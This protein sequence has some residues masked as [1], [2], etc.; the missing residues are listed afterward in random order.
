MLLNPHRST[1]T[2]LQYELLKDQFKAYKPHGNSQCAIQIVLHRFI[3]V[4]VRN[5]IPSFDPAV[6]VLQGIKNRI[7]I[8]LF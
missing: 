1:K 7:Y 5:L 3:N 6:M 2:N 4:N 8:D